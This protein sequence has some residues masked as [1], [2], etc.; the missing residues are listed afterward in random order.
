MKLG[1]IIPYYENTIEAKERLEFLLNILMLQIHKN[2]EVVVVDDGS[3]A[4]WLDK[5]EHIE[6]IHLEENKGVSYARNVGIN[7]LIDKTDYIGFLDA[8]DSISGDYIGQAKAVIEI[9]KPDYVDCRLIQS[10][11]EVFGTKNDYERQKKVVRNG[12]V[13]CFY[14]KEIIGDNRFNENL[15]IGEDGDFNNRVVDLNKHKKGISRGMY[16]CNH[17]VNGDS[18]TMRYMKGE[19]NEYIK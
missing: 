12:V 15:Q 18:I 2:T 8:D 14:K 6:V 13:G 9:E 5:H 16:V 17:G 19:I 7:A 4:K 1:I 3:N 10:G 11:I